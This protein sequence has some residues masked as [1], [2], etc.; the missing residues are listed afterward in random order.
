MFEAMTIER[1]G[2][3][4]LA[5]FAGAGAA[6]GSVMPAWAR[7]ASD[8]T[9]APLPT[10]SGND[11]A[12]SIGNVAVRVDGKVRLLPIWRSTWRPSATATLPPYFS[13]AR[14]RVSVRAAT[15]RASS[16]RFKP[17]WTPTT[18]IVWP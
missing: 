16:S 2:F 12:L 13:E 6:F 18:A 9:V 14:G 3:L 10:V 1:H 17:T 4:G 8:G 11:I 7:S 15:R 5:G